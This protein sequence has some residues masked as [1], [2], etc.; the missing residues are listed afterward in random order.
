MHI[1]GL[2]RAHL[3]DPISVETV[4]RQRQQAGLLLGESLRHG[5]RAIVGPAALVR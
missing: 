4:E 5:A 2:A 1:D 3:L